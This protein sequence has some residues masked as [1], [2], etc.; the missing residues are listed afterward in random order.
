[1]KKN[2]ARGRRGSIKKVGET[3]LGDGLRLLV[4]KFEPPR[5]PAIRAAMRQASLWA[6]AGFKGRAARWPAR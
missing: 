1:V 5:E 2:R 6:M 4:H 3:D